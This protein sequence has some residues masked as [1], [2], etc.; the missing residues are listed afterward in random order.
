MIEFIHMANDL[1]S[2]SPLHSPLDWAGSKP[3]CSLHMVGHSG[4]QFL[5]QVFSSL[6]IN[7][8]EIQGTCQEQRHFCYSGNSKDLVSLLG[9]RDKD[10]SN[11]LLYNRGLYLRE[12]DL[13]WWPRKGTQ[14][15]TLC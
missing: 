4:D 12:Q 1:I 8:G 15:F 11:S 7:S 3:W 10:Q 13:R 2:L 5:V 6:S 9:T 14:L